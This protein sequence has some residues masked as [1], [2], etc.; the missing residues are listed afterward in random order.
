MSYAE[1]A[2]RELFITNPD[3]FRS[4]IKQEDVTVSKK[5]LGIHG[6]PAGGNEGHLKHIQEKAS[7]WTSRMTNGHLPHHMAWVACG[8]QAPTLA[9]PPIPA[10]NH[11]Q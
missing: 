10:G 1:M 8:I 3:G 9:R 7:M 6:L 11:D 4:A 2:P 5:T